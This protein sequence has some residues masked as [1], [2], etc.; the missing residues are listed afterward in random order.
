MR[1]EY[2]K[3]Y[4]EFHKFTIPYG[5][6]IHH[7]DGNHE[8]NSIENLEML[9]PDEHATRHGLISNWIM[10]GSS[11]T[12]RAA[13]ALR[14]PEIR[15]KMRNAMLNSKPH[16]LS[17]K[18]R[19]NNKNWIQAITKHCQEI[20]KTRTNESWNKGKKGMQPVT[21]ETRLKISQRN[22][23]RKWYTNGEVSKF[24]LPQHAPIGYREGR[25]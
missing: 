14:K 18:K 25:F 5:Y 19:S 7:K 4:A 8:N 13:A 1:R 16:K 9:S 10:A 24:V 3:I 21:V 20:A 2:R 12:A 15:E 22:L 23:G 17:L 11:A 6:H